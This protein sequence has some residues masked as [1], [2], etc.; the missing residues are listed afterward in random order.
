[1][2]TP[3]LQGLLIVGAHPLARAIASALAVEGYRVLLVDTN[4]EHI[5]AARLAGLPAAYASILSEEALDELDLAGIGRL[6]A[7]ASNDEVNALAALYFVDLFGRAHVYQLPPEIPGDRRRDP[8]ARHLRGRLLFGLDATY[9]N[10][11]MR[12]AAGAVIKTTRLTR[13]F[14]FTAFQTHYG[15]AALPL[16]VQTETG[17][18][19]IYSTDFQPSPQPAQTLVCLAA[20]VTVPVC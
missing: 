6:L 8:V 11:T 13:E 18:L 3:N 7:L 16:F 17:Q 9:T 19:L 20:A 2:A 14:D 10:L 12:L 15:E 5:A 4:W 1:M